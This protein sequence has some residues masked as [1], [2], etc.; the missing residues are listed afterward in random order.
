MAG[1]RAESGADMRPPTHARVPGVCLAG[2]D[3]PAHLPWSH[4]GRARAGY[5]PAWLLPALPLELLELQLELKYAI[6]ELVSSTDAAAELGGTSAAAGGVSAAA[7]GIP[8]AAGGSAV[9]A[10]S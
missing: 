4:L 1:I 10:V 8:A 2:P 7:G 6:L 5:S 9:G 3:P